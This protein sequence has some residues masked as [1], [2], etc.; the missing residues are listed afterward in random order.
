MNC[1]DLVS[2]IR[3]QAVLGEIVFVFKKKI[4]HKNTKVIYHTLVMIEALVKNC[5]R[6][7]HIAINNES[8][9]KEMGKVAKKFVGKIGIE[10]K[11]VADQ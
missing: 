9:L 1:V 7:M 5:G 8:F 4:T 3:S 11:E 2:N 10:S 6:H